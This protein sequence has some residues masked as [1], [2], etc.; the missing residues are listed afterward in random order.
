MLVVTRA[1]MREL[2]RLTIEVHG[3]PGHV[4]MERAGAGATEAFWRAFPGVRTRPVV[5][6]GK[7][8]NGGDG[9]VVARS[10]RKRGVRCEVVLLARAQD[11]RGDAARNLRA[12]VR[13]RGRLIE[14][15]GAAGVAAVRGAL[16]GRRVIIDAIFGT[17][18]NAPVEGPVAE[19]ISLI[20]ACGLPVFA[21]DI[22]S[23]LDADRG[24]ALGTA[25]QAEATATF[26]FPKVGQVLYPGADHVGTLSVIDIGIAA[27]AVAAVGPKMRLLAG[28]EMGVLLAPRRRD[29]H[30]GDAGHVLIVAGGRGK[31]GAA[32]LA[33]EGA[34]RAGAGL[35]TLALPEVERP[36]VA[37][38]LREVMTVSLAAAADG[39]FGAPVASELEGIFAT[40]SCVVVGPGIGV[41]DGTRALV[42]A[43]VT[44]CPLP[45]VIDAD[46]LN[47]LADN[48]AA[49]QA[50][51][52]P[53]VLTPHP[54]EMSRLIGMPIQAVQADRV[55]VARQCATRTGA[56]VVLKGARTVVATPD[57][58]A[59]INLTGNPGMASG[60]MGDVLAGVI[61][62]LC[63]QGLPAED[64]AGLAVYLHGMA[65]DL[66]AAERGGE[67]GLIASDV[68]GSLPRAIALTQ[69]MA[70]AT[71]EGETRGPR[72][73]RGTSRVGRRAAAG[74]V[75]PSSR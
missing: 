45:L 37:T 18:L 13:A 16:E 20:N 32:V 64:A 71:P 6:A 35:T 39:L 30:K 51:P 65:A 75:H 1:E 12:F 25:V 60:G 69:A 36:L 62:A 63:A 53:T 4:L 31:C 42:Q 52:G 33:A 23:G 47:C 5:V 38:Q 26:G 29:A 54:G 21:I 10:L 57:G 43:L 2:D 72:K 50:R 27:E 7:G 49:L 11:V 8:N 46:G 59:A 61:G 14:A 73:R 70:F 74:R 9:F 48:L 3:T 56:C 17:G 41:S 58:S 34:A 24:E 15:P 40:K 22:P 44:R 68:I 55:G 67:I 28:A 66:A 19:V